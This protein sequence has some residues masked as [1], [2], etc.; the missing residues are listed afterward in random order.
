MEL[1]TKKRAWTILAVGGMLAGLGACGGAEATPVAPAP[2][3]DP[4]AAEG[5]EKNG[6]KGAPGEKHAC[7]G[8]HEGD[9]AAPAQPS[10][11]PKAEAPR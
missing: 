9:N 11:V 3:A 6:C 4:S 8:H 5:P 1:D 2:S 7:N 10:A